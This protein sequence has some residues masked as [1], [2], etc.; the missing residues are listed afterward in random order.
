MYKEKIWRYASI[1]ASVDWFPFYRGMFAVRSL[2]NL[3]LAIDILCLYYTLCYPH[4]L[5][6]M[7]QIF[8]SSYKLQKI[9]APE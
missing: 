1:P 5:Y 6:T 2:T 8:T 3:R 4:E 7:T 9:L